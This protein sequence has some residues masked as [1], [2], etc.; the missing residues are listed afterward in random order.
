[1]LVVLEG[2]GVYGRISNEA[3]RSRE[4]VSDPIQYNDIKKLL[5]Y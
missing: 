4:T 5:E 3:R 2:S 1:L